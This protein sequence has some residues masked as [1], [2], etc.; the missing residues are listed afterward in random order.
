L[1]RLARRHGRA[2]DADDLLQE[3]L[4]EAFRHDRL[5]LSA[6][7]NRAWLVGVLRNKAKMA[8]RGRV[9]R[10]ARDGR[11]VVEPEPAPSAPP[12]MADLL[13]GLPPSLRAVAALALAGQTRREIAYLL[14]LTDAA[15][16]Q[17]LTALRRA[18]AARGAAM[19][20]GLPG[21]GGTLDYGRI[22]DALLPMLLRQ[23]GML[24]AH[25][26]DGHLFVIRG[27]QKPAPRQ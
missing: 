1:Q 21:L 7:E 13:G 6:A 10:L 3:A 5:D 25:D 15:L 19:P 8:A 27:S 11:F 24:A 26:P 9:R 4:I 20:D 22:R 23:R 17:R 2:E 12:D 16:R 14:R 18:L